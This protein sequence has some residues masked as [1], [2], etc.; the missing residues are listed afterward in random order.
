MSISTVAFV[1]AVGTFQGP[2][3]VAQCSVAPSYLDAY[4]E[5]LAM[6]QPT[7]QVAPVSHLVLVR[8]VAELTLERGQLLLLPPV[9]GCTIGAVFRGEGRFRFTPPIPLEQAEL[10]RIDGQRSLDAPITEAVLIFMD[11]TARQLGSLQFATAEVPGAVG[12]HVNDRSE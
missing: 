5:I 11:S 9:G 4:R 2:A 6:K 12:N 8:D 3:V 10:E 7:G 1:L